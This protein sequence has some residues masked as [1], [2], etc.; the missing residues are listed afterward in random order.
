MAITPEMARAELAKR[1]IA[2]RQQLSEASLPMEEAQPEGFLSKLPRNIMIGLANLGQST[3]N[4]PHDLVQGIEQGTQAFG[5][6]LNSLLPEDLGNFLKK[7][8][9][10]RKN[11]SDII[12]HYEENFAQLFGQEGEGTLMDKILQKGVEYAPELATGKAL[13]KAG[14]RKFPISQRMA[15]KPL[16]EAQELARKKNIEPID[17]TFEIFDEA[18]PFL[19]KSHE[20]KKMLSDAWWGDYDALFALQSDL[21]REARALRKSPIAAER[22]AAPEVQSLKKRILTEMKEKLSAQGHQDIA[23]LLSEGIDTYR[24][25]MN[26]KEKVNPILKKVGIPTSILAA[27]GVGVNKSKKI[28]KD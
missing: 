23:D 9:Q 17:I 18:R 24:K 27:L 6:S 8:N 14:L 15:G 13:L 7:K 4:I 21:G 26:F 12:P 22:R 16:K 3:R 2:R 28:L 5:N 19:N 1:E 20:T 10:S 11:V 25:Y